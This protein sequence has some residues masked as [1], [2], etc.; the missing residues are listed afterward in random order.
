MND[1]EY[2][3]ADWW[4]EKCKDNEAEKMKLEMIRAAQ[5]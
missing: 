5:K 3:K 2:Q 1:A 4:T